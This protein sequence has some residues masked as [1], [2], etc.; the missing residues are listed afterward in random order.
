MNVHDN[1]KLDEKEWYTA[2][3]IILG[4][5]RFWFGLLKDR[6]LTTIFK[7]ISVVL[8]PYQEHVSCSQNGD[9]TCNGSKDQQ[10]WC[11]LHNY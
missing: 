2:V 10:K 9:N 5:D 4:E 6:P 11:I 7:G 1:K 3:V 8:K